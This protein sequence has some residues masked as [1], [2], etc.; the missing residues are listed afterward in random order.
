[1]NYSREENSS[2]YADSKMMLDHSP[3]KLRLTSKY[4]HGF[5]LTLPICTQLTSTQLSGAVPGLSL[6]AKATP[7]KP[8]VGETWETF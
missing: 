1:L 3:E 4:G 8:S 6:V 2:S 5:L 7:Q